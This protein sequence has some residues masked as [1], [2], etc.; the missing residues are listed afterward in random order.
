MGFPVHQDF[1]DA[2]DLKDE[3][4]I[5]LTYS[6]P[7][8]Q[9]KCFA[10]SK[11]GPTVVNP[12]SSGDPATN[13]W[14]FYGRLKHGRIEIINVAPKG[15]QLQSN[16][17]GTVNIVGNNN[18]GGYIHEEKEFTVYNSEYIPLA[19]WTMVNPNWREGL[20]KLSGHV[21]GLTELTAPSWFLGLLGIQLHIWNL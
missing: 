4:A 17:V 5:A 21:L 12:G 14:V 2:V 7:H 8:F 10:A 15:N 1:Q 18:H 19:E 13:I 20:A 6:T 11:V 9:A 16:V 3:S